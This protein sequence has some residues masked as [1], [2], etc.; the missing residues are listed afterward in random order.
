MAHVVSAAI[1]V[2]WVHMARVVPAAQWVP[3]VPPVVMVAPVHVV[4]VVTQVQ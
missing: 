2:Q 3:L 4:S 1:Q